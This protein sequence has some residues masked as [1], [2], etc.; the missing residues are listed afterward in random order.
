[1]AQGSPLDDSLLVVRVSLLGG[2][3]LEGL[4][5][6]DKSPLAGVSLVETASLV[7]VGGVDPCQTLESPSEWGL[8]V[9]S[10]VELSPV[11][12]GPPPPSE[13]ELA[14]LLGRSLASLMLASRTPA[15]RPFAASPVVV[16]ESVS[17]R[18][19]SLTS[20]LE[21]TDESNVGVSPTEAPDAVASPLEVALEVRASSRSAS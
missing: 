12:G 1:M 4:L 6:D 21:P 11:T 14:E 7:D 16:F 13:V 20:V 17:E 19:E 9:L 10:E 3:P 15:S 8:L 18:P 5:L 2:R